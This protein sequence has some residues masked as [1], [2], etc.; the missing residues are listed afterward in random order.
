MNCLLRRPSA[1]HQ[2]LTAPHAIRKPLQHIATGV[3]SHPAPNHCSPRPQFTMTSR[4]VARRAGAQQQ[5]SA[6]ELLAAHVGGHRVPGPE[7]QKQVGVLARW[8]LVPCTARLLCARY[9]LPADGTPEEPGSNKRNHTR[10]LL[11]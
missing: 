8:C 2:N 1:S 3:L 10:A 11:R 4:G 5:M 9:F 6:A 7:E